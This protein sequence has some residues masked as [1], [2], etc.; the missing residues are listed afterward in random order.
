ML[1]RVQSLFRRKPR[2]KKKRGYLVDNR[3]T[4]CRLENRRLLAVTWTNPNGGDWS[5]PGN[6]SGNALPGPTDDVII[7]FA[8]I[9]I[10]HTS[11][12]LDTIASLTTAANV[13]LSRGELDVTGQV[14]GSGALTLAGGTL[15]NATVDTGMT[16]HVADA[17]GTLSG[18]TLAGN[19]DLDANTPTVTVLGGLTLSGG[20]VVF[21]TSTYGYGVLRFTNLAA[22]LTGTG[23]VTFNNN[24]YSGNNTIQ[25][26]TA[27]GT[28]T[29]GPNVTISGGS[30]G[31]GYNSSIGGP[32]NVTFVNQGTIDADAAGTITLNGN[33][34]WSNTGTIE[35]SGGGNLNLYGTG[36]TNAGAIAPNTGTLN[37][38]NSSWSNT[39]TVTSTNATVNLGGTFTQ[40][41]LGSFSRTGGNVNLT[42]T[43]TNTGQTLALT[44][45]TGSWSLVGGTIDGG[46]VSV[47]GGARL[48][49]SDQGGTLKDGVT[50]SGD[51]AE[52][53]PIA[54]D[55]ATTTPHVTIVA[56]ALTLA[57][58]TIAFEA[59]TYGYGVLAFTDLAASLAGA[60]NVT[61]NNNYYSGNNTIQEATAG[62]TLTIGTNVT[63]S[64]GSGGIGYNSSIGGPANVTF[65]NQGTIDADAAGTITLNGNN[66][67]SNTGTI[68]SSG[69]G[70]LNLYG[71]G[72]SNAGAIAPNTGT[73]N[74]GNSSWSNT[75]TV[76]STN[77]T[78]NLGG[79]FTQA[80][81][82]SFSR[83]GGNVNLT[84]TLTDT[85]QTL[86][87]TA[88]TGSWSLVGGTIDGGTVSVT[89]GAR[90]EGSDQ[91]GTL[92][93]GVT[94]SGDPAEMDPIVLDLATNGPHVTIA[95]GALT[96]SNATIVFEAGTYGYGV[97]A[98]TDLAASLAGA[99]NV[100][101]NNNYYSGNN[102]I[103]EATAGGTLT[104]GTNVTISGG[105]GGIGYNS[106]IGGPANVTF[107]NQGTI[108]AD[109]AGTITLNGNNGWSNTGTIESS[110]GGNLNLYG[111]G[112]SNAGAIAPNTGTL[113]L[114]NSSWSNTGT[115]TSTNAT[116]NLGGT[117]TQANLGS[118]SRTGGNVNLTG[119]LTDTGQTLALTATT[120]SWSLVGGTIDGGTVS[121]TGGARLEGS[122]QGGTLK[123]GVTLSGDPAETNPIALDLATTTPH[124]TIVAGALTLANATIAYEAGTYGY[125]VLAFTDLAALLTG[126]G[127]V[128]FN[129]N[130]YSGD[131][132][133][134]EATAGGT[135][136]IGPNITISGGSGGIGYN[137]YPNGPANVSF[138][139][140]GTID[141]DA[142]GTITLN[143]NNGWS[144]TGTIESSGGGNL[145]LY[146]TG[147][148]NAGTISPNAG[149]LNLGNS[150][151]S[152][153]GTVTSTNATVNLGGTFTQ[154]NLGS[155]SRTG[156]NVNLTGT[157]TNTGQ[158]LALT[159]TTGSW[160][161]VGGTI[162]GGTVSVTG[163]ARLEGSD[164]G[165]TLKDGVTLSGDPAETNPI[166]LD[167]ATTTPHVTIVAGALTLANATIAYEAGTYGYGVLAF[168]D[169]AALL[170]GTGNVTFNNNYYSG[171]N[172][173]QEATAGGTLT[174][175]PNVTISGG[176]G[177]IGYN[178]YPGGPANVSFVNQ[179]TIDADAAGTITLN[180]NNGWSNTGTIESSGGGNLNLYGT[181]W[182]N[183]GTI[184]P[185]AGTLN[186]GN[187]SWSNTGTVTST[188]A[189]VN[190]GGTFT[191]ANLGSFSRTGGNVNLTG[192]LTNTG[193]TLAL[194]ATTG[195]W[196][197]VGGTI[198]GGT[199][200]VTG[201]A[202]LEGSDQGG[203]LKD[204]VT[205]SGDPAETN[206]IAL[207]LATTTPH[208]TIVAG[209]LT[210]ANATIAY[211]AGTYGYGYLS[212]TDTAA[213]LTGAG[214]VTFDNSYYSGYNA[215][216]EATA[217]GTLTIGPNVTISGGT[218]GIGYDSYLGGPANVSLV[219]EGTI[220]A[221]AAGT[222]T[223][224]G[225]N[226]W[227]NS[228]TIEASG[229]GTVSAT[230]APTNFSAGTLTGGTWKV[231]S[232]GTLRVLFGSSIV[233]N[234]ATI[235][236]NGTAA[237]FYQDSA[238]TAA[239][240][241]LT[242][243]A[244]SGALTI[245]NGV[246]INATSGFTNAGALTI[247]TGS[248]INF[249]GAGTSVIPA[250]AQSNLISHWSADGDASDS[251]DNN[252]GTLENG[253]GF[254]PGEIGQ[255]F[256]FQNGSYVN[257]GTSASLAPATITVEYWVYGRSVNSDY[258]QTL[259]RWGN[260]SSSPNSW[261]FDYAPNGIYYFSVDNASGTQ[262]NAGSAAPLAL[263]AWHFVAGTYNGTTVSLYV[264]GQL[265]GTAP[266]TGPIQDNAS[267]TSFGTKFADGSTHYS[268]NGLIDD[269]GIY[270]RAL[271][272]AELL[273]IYNA[274]DA[275]IF[276]Q[277]G[278]QTQLAG[279]T[280]GNSPNSQVN[281]NAGSLG[282][283]GTIDANVTNAG[284]L[285][286]G[287]PTGLLTIDGSYTQT[288]AGQM[289]V[290]LAGLAASQYSTL[291]VDG[292]ATLAG[293]LNVNAGGGFTAP[294]G[295]VFAVV[296]AASVSGQFATVSGLDSGNGFDLST[297]YYPT[298]VTLVSAA[299]AAIVITPT[300]G[301]T[302]SQAGGTATFTAVLS[303]QPTANVSFGLSSSNTNE[304]L[305]GVNLIVNGDAEAQVGAAG[306][307]IVAPA[308]WTTT[309]NLSA[310][311]YA[312][313]TGGG[314]LPNTPGP[315]ERGANF[316]AGG[317]DTALSTATQTVDVSSSAALIDAG[318]MT[319]NLAGWLGGYSSQD[320]NATLQATFE[321]ASG[322]AL[323]TATIGPVLA[324]DRDDIT[325][326][327]YRMATGLLPVGTR[328]VV[329]L[330]TMTRDSGAYDDGYADDLSFTLSPGVPSGT[331]TFTPS[332]WNEPQT[333]TITG[334]NDLMAEGNVAYTI[335]MTPAV[336]TDPS[337]SGFQP[338]N[339]SVV[340]QSTE[341]AGITVTPTSGLV[342]TSAGGTA[343]FS[344][345]LNSKPAAEVDLPLSSSNTSQGTLSTAQLV[346]TPSNWNQPQTVTITGAASGQYSG[347]IAYSIV[348]AASSS[349]DSN[350]S[351]DVPTS[352]SVTNTNPAPDLEVAN[353]RVTPVTG[354][355]SGNALLVQWNDANAGT[356]SVTGS[357]TDSIVV[358]NVTTGQTLGSGTV[359]YNEGTSGPIA[360]GASP[361]MQFGFTLPDG[362][363]G[364]GQIQFTVTTNSGNTI[365]E[366]NPGGTAKTNNTASTTITSTLA[367]Y[368][369]LQVT[370][371][372]VTAPSGMLAG[373]TYILSWDDS[374]NGAAATPSGVSWTD[375]VTITNTTTGATLATVQVPYN[376][377]PSASGPIA[378]G[379]AYLQ[380]Y[381][382]TLPGGTAGTG[383]IQFTVVVN[384][385]HAVFEYNS[386]GTAT[387][388]NS[389]SITQP[390]A[391]GNY[392]DL[393]VTA[394]SVTPSSSLQSGGSL[395]VNWNDS[396]TGTAAAGTSWVDSLV[397]KNTTTGQTLTTVTLPYN[398]GATANAPL[399][400]GQ[401]APQRYTFPLPDGAAG[402]GQ[403]EAT[404]TVNSTSSLFEY[405]TAGTAFSNDTAAVQV[406][407]AIAPYPDLQVENL[408]I[409]TANI[410]SGG[411][412][413]LHWQDAN[414]GNGPASS[415]WDDRVII[416]NLS[417]SQT[418]ATS[419]LVYDVTKLGTLAAGSV[420][421]QQ[422][423]VTLPAGMASVGTL[424]FS[425]TTDVLNQVF[426][427]NGSGNWRDEQHG[428][429]QRR[430][431]AG[432][433]RRSRG[434]GAG[435]HTVDG[436]AIGQQRGLFME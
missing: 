356:G 149:T 222:I 123:D 196:S 95:G 1:N 79:T 427:Y 87:L 162:D 410:Y 433:G 264:D 326:L 11:G 280:L 302:T 370:N 233:T 38:G 27:G 37:L 121:V 122:D 112:W 367:S 70:N 186:L 178:T 31:I 85:G 66:G 422:L 239:L 15:G 317:P 33:N 47:T 333:V 259:S 104:I 307:D 293:G 301:L 397:I 265:A 431:G 278:G 311:S 275:G 223:L 234:A 224:G 189:T 344:V 426:E 358:T 369:D 142:A 248:A 7:N 197:L 2:L 383:Q 35:S 98:F 77:A 156:G 325:E 339:V 296:N 19:L 209:A 206:P 110:G 210:L 54:L 336:S 203:T 254:A 393:Q 220:D 50:L 59:G 306:N 208:V 399:G 133:I 424:Q 421:N 402:A 415:S 260:S 268:F 353:L 213:S 287:S 263:N 281:L 195:S 49:G 8:G 170:T 226:G 116:V 192:T 134:Q 388:N 218:G 92:K 375:Q 183:A 118:F 139:N 44:A 126:T 207:D 361:G 377:S 371:L 320:D 154:A 138:V 102:T 349:T 100:T 273:T 120:G 324:A 191:Q 289:N 36:W 221:D 219:N 113:N 130:Y 240:S 434:L 97:L 12:A 414:L 295:T 108:D 101:F 406:T 9:T 244:A 194:T 136:T 354:V 17:G 83:T 250:S 413:V 292:S 266:L 117:F 91:G 228:G 398:I 148:T 152:N 181:G 351:G 303:S 109:A 82:G 129:N 140:Q 435:R 305:L 237:N 323:G 131:N 235:F 180:G 163:G 277:T 382:F 119:T 65:V 72:W 125:G 364:T 5:T 227:T 334:V 175:G 30:G 169:L 199:V 81:L 230:S 96:L 53:N 267:T 51:P 67:W 107:V 55:L 174:I 124:V 229:G 288:A 26:A 257:A 193:Q 309:G 245:Q 389:A 269:V 366:S 362:V 330:L 171:D 425:V 294:T 238:T 52:T 160:S 132:T 71:T 246:I 111:T 376:A 187:S 274:G 177:G 143:G 391:L 282:G 155:F 29:I 346:F 373:G 384:A 338:G 80:N 157:L 62:E 114:G 241:G 385:N 416:T 182:T 128:T 202:R 315:T 379:G 341:H 329:L 56:G 13:T 78:V 58:A 225:K 46:T 297:H 176:S 363:A 403:I 308:G 150:S 43:L 34:G 167:L 23:N 74:L 374:N 198:D 185:N 63:I 39:G 145:N 61:F 236:L 405:N 350:Y 217:G 28:L 141:A 249:A 201:G 45:T 24:Y 327:L 105:S 243:N 6:W 347:N 40:A 432:A 387:S 261:I 159:A 396:N 106:S 386:N 395:T 76:T 408:G 258:T 400:T 137:T 409:S 251:Q 279:G 283:T 291:V 284:Q 247:G 90:L 231:T 316:F 418:L 337:Y 321:G 153:T 286:P 392:P 314:P 166:A 365:V 253:A 319:Y 256:N 60:G 164:Q 184:S 215:L 69:G 378:A 151:W 93:D 436:P 381:S 10:T 252:P 420:G 158:T 412:L 312:E 380:Q 272:P 190:L 75:G 57:N 342:T 48:E 423:A 340:N 216:Q 14:Q 41:N 18:V 313:D 401:S 255:A 73:L 419:T 212:F 214:N 200:S 64:G 343:S 32:A 411:S 298:D 355:Q 84:G 270:N 360:P 322:N 146:G 94:L 335:V 205:L 331:L 394:L 127:N 290:D 430:I 188:N 345:V 165:G 348:F 144:N 179:G 310:V 89:G 417:S 115:V 22:S 359:T 173:I 285:S 3:P 211:E 390:A 372:G 352:V 276:T 172:T 20:N 318:T 404:V 271:T 357:F 300:T 99:G 103:Q 86:A 4:V 135:L 42:G 428:H 161:L 25:E 332:D 304:G 21:E 328:Q 368:P 242:T 407:S 168:T 147:W 299:P 429:D 68:E 204:G 16:I 88:T 232:P 262:A